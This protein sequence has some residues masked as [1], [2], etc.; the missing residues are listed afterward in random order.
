MKQILLLIF[1]IVLSGTI[2]F[3]QSPQAFKYQAIIRNDANEIIA[4]QTVGLR[5]SILQGSETGDVIYVETWIV[6]TND[7]G[8]VNLNIGEGTSSDNFSEISWGT[9]NYYVKIELDTEGGS[10]YTEM[11]ISQLLSVPYALYS[12]E[13][14]TSGNIS[15]WLPSGDN[16]Y[17]NAGN[18]G[19]GTDYPNAKFEVQSN[20]FQGDTLFCVKD[21]SGYPVFTVFSD[22][23]QVTVPESPGKSSHGGRFLVSGRGINKGTDTTYFM[24]TPD[25]TRVFVKDQANKGIS[26]GFAVGR[27]ATAKGVH[28]FFR[29]DPL[30]TNV[31]TGVSGGFAVGRYATAKTGGINYID[32]TPE[33]M[34]IGEDAGRIDTASGINNSFL[35]S[36]AGYY[37][38]DGSNNIFIG[39]QTGYSNEQ[40]SYNVF[41]GEK[42]GRNN[43]SGNANVFVGQESGYNNISGHANVFLGQ[44][45]GFN[46][47]N[48]T[49]NVFLGYQAGYNNSASNN[50][51]IG[52]HAGHNEENSNRLYIENSDKNYQDALLY[53]NFDSDELRLNANVGIAIDNEGYKLNVGG[54]LN[55][56]GGLFQNGVPFNPGL[57][58]AQ[59]S[60]DLGSPLPYSNPAE[61]FLI[62]N[63]GAEQPNG[64]YYWDNSQWLRLLTSSGADLT[65]NEVTNITLSSA[66]F[67]GE[68]TDNGGSNVTINGFCWS[69]EENPDLNNPHTADVYSTDIFTSSIGGLT[70]YETYFVKA[71]AINSAGTKYGNQVSF[72]TSGVAEDIS[73]TSPVASTVWYTRYTYNIEWTDNIADNVAIE[74]WKSGSKYSDIVASAASNGTYAWT[75]PDTLVS[76]TDYQ[77]K[78]INT[79]NTSVNDISENFEIVVSELAVTSP[80][81]SD[82]WIAGDTKTI[83]WTSN[84][85]ENVKIE[86]YQGGS[87]SQTIVTSTANDGTH[88][89]NVPADILLADDYTV[90]IT[91]TTNTAVYYESGQFSIT[92]INYTVIAHYPFH[93][94]ANDESSN[95]NNGTVNGAVLTADR[96]GNPNNAYQFDGVDDYI[97][98]GNDNSM[99]PDFPASLSI[100]VNPGADYNQ[101][102][103]FANDEM[104]GTAYY[105]GLLVYLNP[106]GQV[107]SNIGGGF[108]SQSSRRTFTTDNSISLNGWTHVVVIWE[109]ATSRQIYFNGVLQNG[110]WDD[111]TATGIRYT[112][113]AAAFGWSLASNLTYFGGS[114]D[115][116]YFYNKVL[117]Q[118]EVN[119]LY[120]EPNPQLVAY[121]PFNGNA[122]DESGYG[123]DGTVNGATLTTDRFGVADKA[124]SFDGVNDYIELPDLPTKSF[125]ISISAFFKKTGNSEL[126]GY[127]YN[128]D[129]W[130]QYWG[131]YQGF[132]I[133]LMDN[134]SIYGGF[135]GN[136]NKAN[137]FY[138]SESQFNLDQWYHV[139][140]VYEDYHDIRIYLNGN[141]LSASE[142]HPDYNTIYNTNIVDKIGAS[143]DGQ[144]RFYYF[145]SID[146]FKIY[147]RI[148]TQTEITSLYHEGGWTGK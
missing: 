112:S 97:D 62:Y 13:S 50:V 119:D 30:N 102:A 17:Y 42:G 56:N 69:T 51:F 117:S 126:K 87:L 83:T 99:K 134:G 104:D 29:T 90:K 67:K 92:E 106:S 11:G 2:L 24:V 132:N 34:F 101:G 45:T 148:L 31:V 127:L 139:C 5:I 7:F 145:G 84:L 12:N 21:N 88:E 110:T 147:N 41:L 37:N 23:V 35:G 6:E 76:G 109:S 16:I 125:P 43:I 85:P 130:D 77:I 71:Y 55:F 19:I 100:W 129:K 68:I 74:L 10:N 40:G 136:S 103:L 36:K 53:G 79:G 131:D 70:A 142:T 114:L 27:Y 38:Q 73:I 64:F 122:N 120:A 9:Y 95:N 98:L 143:S 138:S 33:N 107:S 32:I 57:I 80:V 115:D 18:V 60:G 22:A 89:Y 86:L 20:G 66:D 118:A 133:T 3:A 108:A 146:D 47:S 91:S 8:L 61:G 63:D 39:Q 75:I 94:N 116:I 25:S 59:L 52:N 96:F 123:N 46:N 82:E 124:Y 58:K 26:G 113:V 78:I 14:G 135:G 144:G 141:Q 15:P 49:N 121:Y 128:S 137:Y 140:I 54:D 93:G 105:N 1:G 81:T 28:N 72:T 44:R 48:G 111:G 4:N 65:T